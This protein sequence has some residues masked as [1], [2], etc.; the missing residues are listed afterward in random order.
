[1][2]VL[3]IRENVDNHGLRLGNCFY[4]NSRATVRVVP[5]ICNRRLNEY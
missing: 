5:K 4:L 2:T 1:M 3:S